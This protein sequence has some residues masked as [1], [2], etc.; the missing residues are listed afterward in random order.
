MNIK[1]YLR[2]LIKAKE[3][4][5]A[6]LRK[7]IKE[8]S[9]AD[10]VRALG[11]TLQA[12]LDELNE[13]KTQLEAQEN[14]G[15]EGEGEENGSVGG[16]GRSANPMHEFR[17]RAQ[18]RQQA[19]QDSD[20]T[21]TVEYRTAFMNFVCRNVPIPVEL[22]ADATTTTGDAGAVI[23]TTILNEI[24][25]EMRVYGELFARVRRLQVQGG[26]EIPISDLKPVA[27][28]ITANTGTSES[29]KQKLS[30]KS[31][32]SFSYF[33]LECKLSQ[34]LLASIVTLEI[35][36]EEFVKL[37][38]EAI[39][40]ALD[41]AI[42]NG[43]GSGEPLGITKDTRVPSGNVITLTAEEFGSWD[44]WHKKVIAKMK[45]AYR[46][47][48]FIMAQGTFD[49]YIDGMVD[50]N[51]QPVGRVNYGTDG[52]EVYRFCGKEVLTVED[53]VVADYETAETGTVV[54]VFV[55]LN[56]YGVNSN[57]QLQLVKWVDHDTNEVKNKAILIADGK[58]IDANGAL[59][60][61]KA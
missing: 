38:V 9:T 33:G 36:Q 7:L 10:E 27:K 29:D 48:T 5:A 59:I 17:T 42:I 22:R 11:D 50:Q 37:A 16:E 31:K 58:L 54:A 6:E 23:P 61:K 53:D 34:S 30:A 26:V 15:D 28:W 3:A 44:G 13:A 45:K 56:N 20:P 24:I 57:M 1:T 35:F 14:E 19:Q 47:G 49:G 25:R 2:N 51:G 12:V 60:I 8:A 41:V 46:K 4:R 18:Y 55:D 40:Q 39:A 32:V 21:N 43:S 52:A